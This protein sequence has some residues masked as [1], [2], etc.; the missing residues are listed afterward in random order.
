M[1]EPPELTTERL[2]LVA[3]TVDHLDHYLA[4]FT[5]ADAS[6]S[7]GGP[8]TESQAWAR[9]AHDRGVWHLRG[10][11]VWV[12][13]SI[14][15]GDVLGGCGFWQALGWPHELTWWLLPDARGAGFAGEASEAAIRF[16]YEELGWSTVQTYMEDDNE[17]ARALAE[18]LGGLPAGRHR[19]PDG[20]ERTIHLLPRPDGTHPEG[21]DLGW[22]DLR[23][24]R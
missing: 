19:F 18:R 10:F 12:I 4:F 2:R 6:A 24:D 11:G 13:T 22:R 9:L 1:V 8:L 16:A 3:P 20:E 7:Y 14:E 15:T 21:A 5:D 23:P 17:P